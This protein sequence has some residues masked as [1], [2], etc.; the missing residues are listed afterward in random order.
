MR[1]TVALTAAL[2]L[3]AGWC[4]ASAARS[5]VVN[6]FPN[7]VNEPDYNLGA[8][9]EEPTALGAITSAKVNAN[10]ANQV[11]VRRKVACRLVFVTHAALSYT[12]TYVMIV[13]EYVCVMWWRAVVFG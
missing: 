4:I 3:A 7:L 12:H 10:V 8:P 11:G 1:A 9:R 5:D 13:L 6:R 2:T